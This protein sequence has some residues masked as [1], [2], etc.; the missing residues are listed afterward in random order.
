VAVYNKEEL[1][2]E[3]I[4]S[5]KKIGKE[6]V[7][8]IEVEG[9]HNFI[10]NDIVAHNT[11]I[12]APTTLASNLVVNGNTILGDASGDTLTFNA[13]TLS[14]PNNLNIDSN[15]LFVDAANNR[16]G[17]GT[18]GPYQQLTIQTS[19]TPSIGFAQT[20][21][22]Y[23][24][25]NETTGGL[26]RIVAGGSG[27]WAE[28]YIK[29]QTHHS[30][31]PTLS[32]SM[33][34]KTGNVGIG[35]TAPGFKLD[36]TGTLGASLTSS[37]TAGTAV[38]WNSTSREIYAY[39]SSL[40]FKEKVTDLEI[41]SSKIYQLRPVSFTPLGTDKRDFGLIAEEVYQIIP[42]LVSLDKE[43]QP[44]SVHYE[45]LSVLLLQELKAQKKEIEELKLRFNSEGIL[46]T[47]T[48][49]DESG[50]M[51]QELG[52]RQEGLFQVFVEKVKQ[53]LASFGLFIKNGIA[54][55]KE[56]ITDVARIK[57]IKEVEE[58]EIR[59]KA[60]GEI[61]CVWLENGEWKKVKS[62]CDNLTNDQL[63]ITND[64][65]NPNEQ[66]SQESESM[67][68]EV[69]DVQ[70]DE[71]VEDEMSNG[72]TEDDNTTSTTDT[73][74]NEEEG[75]MNQEE[76]E[77]EEPKPEP[78]SQSEPEPETEPEPELEPKPEP[79]TEN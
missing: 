8:D 47:T 3:K 71:N 49:L 46:A 42:E 4:V 44:F 32:D 25:S 64:K 66:N 63:L 65:I 9:T 33:I 13:S 51:N 1:V 14:I 45:Q 53:A 28:S 2:F 75:S 30:E 15:T 48:T 31:T 16:V 19:A 5:L 6:K 21:D 69:G 35:T 38:H 7:Y 11:Y 52:N 62:S 18:T 27:P 50:S 56:L 54:R 39:T 43:N 59:D 73:T 67:N 60:T 23:T 40:K 29:F 36:V 55:V 74:S 26:A 70:D 37:A 41:D 17:I 76:K 68:E 34:I 77:N 61:Y 58:F 20:I 79:E 24:F 10:G 57:K 22:G 72:N 78:E 12:S